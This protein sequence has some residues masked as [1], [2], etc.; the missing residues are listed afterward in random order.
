MLRRLTK[1]VGRY[2]AGE[3]H[4]FPAYV[5]DKIALDLAKNRRLRLRGV[6]AKTELAK[7]SEPV[8][9]TTLQNP[10]RRVHLKIRTGAAAR[11]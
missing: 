4:D 1:D 2:K 8:D 7:F 11:P 9:D 5:W 10:M 3:L 6:N